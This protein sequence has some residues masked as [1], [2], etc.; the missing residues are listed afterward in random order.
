MEVARLVLHD[1]RDDSQRISEVPRRRVRNLQNLT[2]GYTPRHRGALDVHRW[3]GRCDVDGFRRLP[4]SRN[5]H[6]KSLD[7]F[8]HI[9]RLTT[10]SEEAVA[11]RAELIRSR[12]KPEH[13]LS[14]CI[15]NG[16][17]SRFD[18]NWRGG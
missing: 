9:E 14:A 17:G 4:D 3:N 15:R 2:V 16:F 1:S 8:R 5:R 18:R 13:E 12:G 7:G 11:F 6:F 10:K